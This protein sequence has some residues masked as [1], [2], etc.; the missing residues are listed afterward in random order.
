MKQKHKIFFRIMSML[1]LCT[2]IFQQSLF[3]E[4]AYKNSPRSLAISSRLPGDEIDPEDAPGIPSSL[5]AADLHD[6]ARTLG[7][8]PTALAPARMALSVIADIEEVCES[9]DPEGLKAAQRLYG[10]FAVQEGFKPQIAIDRISDTKTRVTVLIPNKTG[11]L[12][13]VA[14]AHSENGISVIGVT[15]SNSFTPPG[16]PTDLSFLTFT[17]EAPAPDIESIRSRIIQELVQLSKPYLPGPHCQRLHITDENEDFWF[18]AEGTKIDKE[19]VDLLN[20][21]A[22]PED[23]VRCDIG[24]E[25]VMIEQGAKITACLVRDVVIK[26]GAKAVNSFLVTK[27]PDE[28]EE[29]K[30]WSYNDRYT[31]QGDQTYVG[32]GCVVADSVLVNTVLRDNPADTQ[33]RIEGSSLTDCELGRDNHFN[34]V[35]GSVF[36][37]EEDVCIDGPTE[38]TEAWFGWGFRHTRKMKIGDLEFE[39]DPEAYIEGVFPNE[40]VT[41]EVNSVGNPV[42]EFDEN[43]NKIPLTLETGEVVKTNEGEPLYRYKYK[44][45]KNIPALSILGWHTIYCSYDGKLGTPKSGMI[46][47]ITGK[48]SEITRDKESSAHYFYVTAPFSVIA[49]CKG[50]PGSRVLGLSEHREDLAD[51][52]EHRR[53][54]YISPCAFVD[55]REVWSTVHGHRWGLSHNDA[56]PAATFTYMPT[57]IYNFGVELKKVRERKGLGLKDTDGLFNALL[58]TFEVTALNGSDLYKAHCDSAVWEYKDG[59]FSRWG[60]NKRT[61]QLESLMFNSFFDSRDFDEGQLASWREQIADGSLFSYKDGRFRP[62]GP[63]FQEWELRALTEERKGTVE[64]RVINSIMSGRK[65]AHIHP[66][67][68]IEGNVKLG[69]GVIIGANVVLRGNITVG[70]NTELNFAKVEGD[71]NIGSD[72]KLS[73]VICDGQTTSVSI[74][75]GNKMTFTKIDAS[76]LGDG[77]EAS[78]AVVANSNFGNDNMLEWFT[79]ARKGGRYSNEHII[80]NSDTGCELLRDGTTS[81]HMATRRE[82]V[83]TADKNTPDATNFSAGCLVRGTENSL[84]EVDTAFVVANTIVDGEDITIAGFVKNKVPLSTMVDATTL[85]D[86][87]TRHFGELNDPRL[88]FQ[89]SARH[90]ASKTL[91]VMPTAAK[92]R[93]D[94]MIEERFL[95][96]VRHEL[97]LL[98][99]DAIGIYQQ[100]ASSVEAVCEDVEEDLKVASKGQRPNINRRIQ[101][102]NEAIERLNGRLQ[103]S[104]VKDNPKVKALVEGLRRNVAMLCGCYRIYKGHF[105][106]GFW[107]KY[108]DIIRGRGKQPLWVWHP[109]TWQPTS[110]VPGIKFGAIDDDAVILPLF[111]MI[112]YARVL[113]EG[114]HP[115]A[116]A[117][118][119]LTVEVIDMIS[120]TQLRQCE[121][122]AWGSLASVRKQPLSAEIE[123]AI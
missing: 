59:K 118:E 52:Y 38:V 47:D 3:A 24:G 66:N 5:T 4:A 11:A 32:K 6:A 74:G 119:G 23:M 95:E 84:V 103:I 73:Y 30:D 28:G 96:A 16:N 106:E 92:P 48:T 45:W 53:A 17:A 83:R 9:F 20:I 8:E 36:H 112:D 100:V 50:T 86:G 111:E 76:T 65:T 7:L 90:V 121:Q 98:N 80:G 123:S 107:V 115:L 94:R 41:V 31:A 43:N 44:V 68:I 82:Y 89:Y 99:K 18:T 81:H 60:V 101:L 57:L 1:L 2:F 12:T 19:K 14:R 40:I 110:A 64:P 42:F 22:R 21:Q 78:G 69:D 34:D 102:V 87:K 56:E 10:K 77:N 35:K 46:A 117:S 33:T 97:L 51:I 61:N 25:K 62:Y 54:T 79:R 27:W 37:S 70:D 108:A 29:F 71:V 104:A 122:T 67:A 105:T 88:G 93:A 91:K 75:S 116:L 58:R 113:G 49:P 63:V 114:V 39:R 72:C 15:S 85:F 120:P 55:G 109:M 13:A 26:A